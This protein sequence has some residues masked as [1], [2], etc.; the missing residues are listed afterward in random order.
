MFTASAFSAEPTP[1]MTFDPAT[2]GSVTGRNFGVS[3]SRSNVWQASG[4]ST[5]RPPSLRRSWYRPTCAARASRANG[6]GAGVSNARGASIS[7]S[8]AAKA[9]TAATLDAADTLGVPGW[10][11]GAACG[12][13]RLL[14]VSARDAFC[15]SAFGV[16]S[17]LDAAD[18]K[19]S[20]TAGVDEMSAEGDT[21]PCG[22][23]RACCARFGGR[24]G[25]LSV[26]REDGVPKSRSDGRPAPAT[27]KSGDALPSSRS[28]SDSA[29]P[30]TRNA[31][32]ISPGV[33]KHIV[34]GFARWLYRA[35]R[36]RQRSPRVV[37]EVVAFV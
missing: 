13:P 1:R 33:L 14:G 18:A 2:P 6:A 32:G 24:L 36:P 19:V 34:L 21:K 9:A 27:P 3:S 8:L 17:T 29:E 10:T 16:A 23:F 5:R 20:P 31:E 26:T 11:G 25:E 12:V 4:G 28:T 30:G 37:S 22:S 35:C 15:A 7:T